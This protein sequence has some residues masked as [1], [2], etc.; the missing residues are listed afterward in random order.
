MPGTEIDV[1]IV[2]AG[3]VGLAAAARLARPD[4]TVVVLE[5]HE[6]HGLETSSRNSEVMHAGLYYPAGSLKA[7]LCVEGRR[8]LC[9]LGARGAVFTR[10]TGKLLAACAPEETPKLEALR[11]QGLANGMEGLELL[12]RRDAAARAPGVRAEAGLWVPETGIIDT[13]ELM[14][15]YLLKAQAAGAIFL[16]NSE[17][18]A[19]ERAQG[20]YRLSVQGQDEAVAARCVINAAGLHA[21]RVA[22]LAG[23]DVAAAGYG[24]HWFKGEYFSLRRPLPISCLVYPVPA[25][26][27]LGIHLAVD[28]QG[29]Q[30][31]GP[32]AFPVD[33]LDYDVDAGH[34][35]AF[36][37]AVSRYLPDVGIE[38]LAPAMSGIRPKLSD[39]G[40]FRDFVIAEESRRGLP[41]WINLVGIESP[42]LTASPAIAERIADLLEWPS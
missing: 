42:G 40:S 21:D 33:N 24:L 30:R 39:D 13:E 36:H 38:D 8:R 5:R 9:E 19:V 1:V 16:W 20:R 31:F 18:T 22:R 32:S 15:H 14:R 41:G 11:A 2:G 12:G 23:I 17:L 26:H 28:R 10:R 37:E 7:R 29:R 25:A 6:R 35:A 27:S 3:V 4:N 34:R